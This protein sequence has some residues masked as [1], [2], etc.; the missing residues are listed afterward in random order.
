VDRLIGAFFRPALLL[1]R[2]QFL[3]AVA[4]I[5]AAM[6]GAGAQATRFRIAFANQNEEPGVRLDGL[7][8]TGLDVRRSFELAA[9]TLPVEM[10]YYDNGGDADKARANAEDAV[11]RKAD[12]FIGYNVDAEANADIGRSLKAAGIRA[13]AVNYPIPGA[14][15]YTADNLAAGRIA[16]RALGAFVRQSWADQTSIAVILGDLGDPRSGLAD[17][18]QG[19]AEGL[20]EELP[21][22]TPAR[23]DTS[24][25]PVRVEGLLVKFLATQPR[26]KVLIATLDDPTALSAKSAV[27]IAGRLGDCVI[28]GQGVDRSVHGGASDK[29]EI[30]PNNRSSIVLGS[31]AYFLDRYGYEVLPLALKMLRGETIPFR[32]ATQHV[33]IT[34]KNVFQIYPPYDMN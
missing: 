1:Q 31:V 30:D 10:I 26:R 5:A 19:I 33:L 29:K 34:A 12:L 28:V 22:I 25:N 3:S 27:E 4:A 32:I 21:D 16:G 8:F 2:R 13:L 11:A 24:G 23:L 14:P 7:G 20:R 15:L 17:R 9:R 6:S 18:Q